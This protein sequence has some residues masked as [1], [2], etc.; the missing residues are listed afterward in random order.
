M[1]LCF[2]IIAVCPLELRMQAH[3]TAIAAPSDQGTACHLRPMRNPSMT[4]K[5]VK[6]TMTNVQLTPDKLIY[7]GVD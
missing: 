6:R 1:R 7:V 3:D 4:Y 2:C 5:G